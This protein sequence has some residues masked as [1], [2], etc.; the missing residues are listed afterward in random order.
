MYKCVYRLVT[1][2]RFD[3]CVS[4]AA[5]AVRGRQFSANES[6]GSGR[7]PRGRRGAAGA[8]RY[9]HFRQ[10]LLSYLSAGCSATMHRTLWSSSLPA[11]GVLCAA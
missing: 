6:S 5:V 10:N 8:V 7:W 2:W 4:A 9:S 3:A 11:C 1:P